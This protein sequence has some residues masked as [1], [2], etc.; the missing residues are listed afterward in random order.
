MG[1]LFKLVALAATAAL[2]VCSC[3]QD[4]NESIETRDAG[5]DGVSLVLEGITTRS[6]SASPV[7][8]YRYAL[9]KDDEGNS[10]SLLETV[11]TMEDFVQDTPET[12][13]TPVYTEN[14]QN[15]YGSSFNG[16]MYKAGTSEQVVGDGAFNIMS[17]TNPLVWRREIGYNPFASANELTFFLRMPASPTGVS[18]LTYGF[19]TDNNPKIEFDYTTPTTAANQQDIIFATRTLTE[20]TYKQEFD[21]KGGASVLFRHALT[22]IKFAIGNNTIEGSD[23]QTFIKKVEFTGLKNKGHVVYTPQGTETNVDDITEFSSAGSFSWT[24]IAGTNITTKYTQTFSE[25]QIRNFEKNDAVKGPDS[26]Y[27]AGDKNNLNKADA[28]LTFWFI[29]QEMT[30]D[31]KL[32]VTFYVKRG[33]IQGQ[34]ITLTLDLGTAILAQSSGVNDEWMAGQLRT[35]TLVPTTVDVDI[36]DEVDNKT[37]KKNVITRNTGNKDVYMRVAIVGNWV[38][39]NGK[40]VAPWYDTQGSFTGLGG[41]GAW[42]E[43]GDGFWYYTQKVA[44]GAT[45]AIPIFNTYTKPSTVPSGATG[46]VMD[47]IVQGIDSAT[48]SNYAAAWSSV[49]SGDD[50]GVPVAPGDDDDPGEGDGS[51]D[52]N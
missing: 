51:G 12:R 36:T 43:G 28:S 35:F 23:V 17:G 30:D 34:D 14:V 24:D 8:N 21:S 45:P 48:G 38:D 18:N 7:R 31:V 39:A 15:V 49:Y 5:L 6:A 10:Y 40:I 16:V 42:V 27:A 41:N 50:G 29:P 2:L 44:P 47:L 19:D 11:T 25:D 22:G 26:F 13:G 20:A 1:K 32:D 52:G 4:Q 37:V 33:A 3:L 46:L 9:G